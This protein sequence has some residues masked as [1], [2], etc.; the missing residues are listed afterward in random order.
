M[1]V[2]VF[3]VAEVCHE[4]NRLWCRMNE[5]FSQKYWSSADEWQQQSAIEGVVFA[6]VNP[7]A[8]PEDQHNAWA[9]SK[10]ADGWAYGDVKDAVKKTHPCLV[11]YSELPEVQKVKDKLFRAIVGA[12]S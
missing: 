11:P 7:D 1:P 9:Q 8:T 6:R 5:D 3:K 2:S 4:V 12:M 10:L